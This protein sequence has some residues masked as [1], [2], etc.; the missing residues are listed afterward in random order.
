M[1][2]C[3]SPKSSHPIT[4]TQSPKDCSAHLCLFCCLGYRVIEN[5]RQLI[6]FI[7]EIKVTYRPIHTL[8][9]FSTITLAD[10]VY[11]LLCKKNYEL[12]AAFSG[13]K[14]KCAYCRT[15]QD[16]LAAG[17]SKKQILKYFQG[18]YFNGWERVEHGVCDQYWDIVLMSYYWGCWESTSSTV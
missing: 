6:Y 5:S 3:H 7:S 1:F 10:L 13:E 8:L 4:L 17:V 15:K 2:Q 16:V 18:K 9:I 11:L 14:K 12:T